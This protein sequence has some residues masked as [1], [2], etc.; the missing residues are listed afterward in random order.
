[1]FSMYILITAA[2]GYVNKLQL[3]V[4]N[5]LK[6]ILGS[7]RTSFS[8]EKL[9]LFHKNRY[10]LHDQPDE[11]IGLPLTFSRKEQWF[12][13]LWL[14]S[15]IS[16]WFSIGLS[17]YYW[18]ISVYLSLVVLAGTVIYQAFINYNF[19]LMNFI[20]FH[21]H[22]TVLGARLPT[23]EIEHVKEQTCMLLIITWYSGRNCKTWQLKRTSLFQSCVLPISCRLYRFNLLDDYPSFL[24]TTRS[25]Y[26]AVLPYLINLDEKQCSR[27]NILTMDHK[28]VLE[29]SSPTAV[30]TLQNTII[31]LKAVKYLNIR[32]RHLLNEPGT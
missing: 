6:G 5:I 27:S 7:W 29:N 30:N 28:P 2:H 16:I 23:W 14:T 8:A 19:L 10:L 20:R 24:H 11:I 22:Q 18:I 26:I 25:I 13:F 12:E 31:Y 3:T 1:M 17:L 9:V 4:K 32:M 15:K 21:A